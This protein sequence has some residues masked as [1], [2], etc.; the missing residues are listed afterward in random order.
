M[1]N[2]F[3]VARK[4]EL[5]RRAERVE[6]TRQRIV[7]ATLA[8]HT[9]IGPARTTVSAIAER[10]GVQ[11]HTFYRHFPDERSLNMACSGLHLKRNPLPDP[12][13][14]RRIADPEERLRRGLGELYAYYERNGAELWPI[15]RDI[16]VA[17]FAREA[18]AVRLQ[19][20]LEEMRCAL[21]EPFGATGRRRRRLVG[22]LT[23]LTDFTAWRTLRAGEATA[24]DALDAAVRA[25]LC[26]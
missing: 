6:D 20:R 26:Q 4:Y 9:T 23:L 11:R 18:V 16:D 12:A 1:C 3:R 8:L 19:P 25:V 7:E 22:L 21:A 17:P 10:A 5:K 2:N 24:A 14:W 13:A 15:M